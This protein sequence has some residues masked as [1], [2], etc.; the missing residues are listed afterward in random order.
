ME[1]TCPNCQTRYRVPEVSKPKHA[2]CKRCG[3]TFTIHPSSPQPVSATNE[4]MG[5][6]HSRQDSSLSQPKHLMLAAFAGAILLILAGGGHP[7]LR[8]W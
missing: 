6:S 8:V 4:G 7:H 2:V 1:A 3:K 5:Q